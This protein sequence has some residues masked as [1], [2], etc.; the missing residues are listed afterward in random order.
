MKIRS[1]TFV[2]IFILMLMYFLTSCAVPEKSEND[3]ITDLQN[4]PNFYSVQEIN[5]ENELKNNK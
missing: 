5:I 2:V 3:I 1:L 4:H